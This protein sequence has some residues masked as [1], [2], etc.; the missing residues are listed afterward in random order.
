MKIVVDMNLAPLWCEFLARESRFT[1]IHWSA[2]GDPRATDATIMCWAAANDHVVLTH[3]LDFSTL[4][5]ATG[6][7]RPSVVQLRG[8]DVMPEAAGPVVLAALRDHV[9]ALRKGAIV[10]LDLRGARLRL[11]PLLR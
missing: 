6:A 10:T 3:D 2:V 8:D 7:A 4:L 1:A 5:A 9:E 11:L